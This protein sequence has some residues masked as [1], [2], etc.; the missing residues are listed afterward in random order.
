MYPLVPPPLSDTGAWAIPRT[1]QRWLDVNPI[2]HLT[3]TQGYITLPAFN[4]N[5]NWLG[6]SDI[7]AAFNF[8]GPNNF[9]LTGFNIEPSPMPNYLL[10][11]MW[12]DSNGNVKRYKLWSGVGEVLYFPVPIYSGQKIAKNFRFEIW[13]VAPTLP[14]NTFTVTNVVSPSTGANGVY[15]WK[16]SIVL[17]TGNYEGPTVYEM[18]LGTNGIWQLYNIGTHAILAYTLNSNIQGP[19]YNVSGY[20]YMTVSLT[21]M[22][23]SQVLPIQI[24]TSVLGK[25]DYRY[26]SDF[27]LVGSDAVVTNFATPYLYL[28]FVFP[29]TSYPQSN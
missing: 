28:P 14:Y 24:Y 18:I 5:V 11:I 7:V 26:G 21:A 22:V 25:Q 4:V 2:T 3:R 10:C 19:Y 20:F 16:Y 8:E 15:D 23:T 17:G 12:R 1:L 27:T 6:Y 13:S 9:S 29:V